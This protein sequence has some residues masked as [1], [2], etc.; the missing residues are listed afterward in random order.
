MLL[1]SLYYIS[2]VAFLFLTGCSHI[3]RS[4]PV[5]N[6]GTAE[7]A[8][9]SPNWPCS[10]ARQSENEVGLKQLRKAVLWN[11]FGTETS[12]LSEYMSDPRLVSL[13]LH[14]INEVCQRHNNCE[15]Y[16]VVYGLTPKEYNH[17]LI[18]KNEKL[19][20]KLKD[21][22][23][24]PSQLINNGLPK[25]V[26]CLINPGLESN[27]TVE[28]A[29][30]LIELVRPYFPNCKIVWNPVGNNPDA[31]PLPRTVFELH[32]D[33]PVLS[34]PCNADLDGVDISFPSRPA[35]VSPNIPS[36]DIPAYIKRYSS[37]SNSFL[38]IAEYNGMTGGPFINPRERTAFPT[39]A[40]FNLVNQALADLQN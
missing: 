11:T 40:T 24:T 35:L 27:L 37:C 34:P 2:L 22:F 25:N 31:K 32:G 14:L 29:N 30:V 38:W 17:R 28:A 13:E 10:L 9:L 20:E 26:E 8:M 19:I 1:K 33:D 18:N 23:E 12:C 16:E 36:S 7:Y 6:G 15:S 21:Y 39:L 5:S 4:S 3:F